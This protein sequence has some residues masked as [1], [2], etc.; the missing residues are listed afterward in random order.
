MNRS[1][2]LL[3]FM[4]VAVSCLTIVKSAT[5]RQTPAFDPSIVMEEVVVL[6][7][8]IPA[9]KRLTSEVANL[10]DYEQLA[11]LTDSSVGGALAR[12]TGLSLVAGKYV[13]VRGLGER[14]S[15]TLMDGA[16]I[17]SPVPFQKT[18]PLDIVPKGLVRNLLVQ[19]TY[20]PDLPADFS[21]GAVMIRTRATPDQNYF[22]LK[23]QLSGDSETTAGDGLSYRGGLS[24]NWG[25][26]DGTR[27][28]PSN[29]RR[30]TSDQFEATPWPE[31]AALGASFL[32]S[33][34]VREKQGLKPNF[35][36]D[37]EF[38]LHYDIGGDLTAGLLASG[39]Y[40]NAWNNRVKEFRRYEFTGID[41]GSTQTV[42]YEQFTT[43]QTIDWSGFV[44]L[45]L[46]F[47]DGHSLRLSQVVLTQT[48]D[49]TQQFKGLSSEDNISDGTEVVSHRL[50][51]TENYIRSTQLKGEHYFDVG[52]LSQ[53]NVSW[54]AVDGAA[55]RDAPD[56]RTSTYAVNSRGFEEIVTPSRQAAGDLREVFQAPDRVYS[57]L[58]DEITEYGIDAEIVFYV[59]DVD[60]VAKFGGSDYQRTRDSES[61]FFRF[62]ITSS[63]PSQ[64]ALM[65]PT[66]LFGLDN[67][68][69]GYLD[70]RDFSAGAANASGI[71]PFARSG[72]E[73]T[74]LYAALDA[75]LTPRIHAAI[76][77]RHETTTLFADAF[78]GNT[79]MGTSN[80]VNRDY[81]D[82]LPAASL[83]LEFVNN[84]QLR[85][86]YSSTL[87]RPSLLEITGTTI[88]NPEDSNLYRGNVFLRP[89]TVANWDAR[90]EWYFG[91]KDSLSVGLFQKTFE[92]PI[93]IGKVQAQNDIFTWF[94]GERAELQGVE[95]E[96]RKE[97]EFGYWFGWGEAWNY[98]DLN[99]NLSLIDSQ[100]TLFGSGETAAD[101]PVTGSRRI[102]QLFENERRLTGQSDVLGNLILS[103]VDLGRGLEG[104]LAYNYTGERIVLVGAENAPNIVEQTRGQL[105]F[106]I[107]Y[108]FEAFD[109]PVEAEFKVQNILD[110][111]VEWRQGGRLY[112]RYDMGV[113]YALNFKISTN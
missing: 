20:S 83:T 58:R 36:G 96:L 64:I 66:R 3:I 93:E 77:F 43:R 8:F 11:L 38:G 2:Y 62:D 25:F 61:R 86:A 32:N 4:A 107:R 97:L 42:D 48:G 81:T 67:W 94:N 106:L 89:A 59:G 31:S 80:A 19:K 12:V 53:L 54:R 110:D 103:Y 79:A 40:A 10:L 46:E 49:E 105:D 6:G 65:T 14:Y 15:S 30:L 27:L 16:R 69:R 91:N 17:S 70:V 1:R 74:S 39:R 84:M 100:V 21:G 95:I 45:G 18:V 73:T 13:Y 7:Q 44:N 87:N 113:S 52:K 108:V 99:A 109:Y 41:G 92:D 85:F 63:A 101:V 29:I 78:G 35:S 47:A 90:W 98:F 111:D 23:V 50:Q 104:S 55:T 102:A 22:S 68:S 82:T 34:E 33:W 71:F 112:E 76:G 24:D 56:T 26:D 5:A 28:V 9:D 75:Q 51:W 37:G 88:R 72:E 60:A 57:E